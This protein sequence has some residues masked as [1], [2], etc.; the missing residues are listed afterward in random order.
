MPSSRV[1]VSLTSLQQQIVSVF[2]LLASDAGKTVASEERLVDIVIRSADLTPPAKSEVVEAIRDLE[3]KHVLVR[4][5]ESADRKFTSAVTLPADIAACQRGGAATYGP[6]S[7]DALPDAVTGRSAKDSTDAAW[8]RTGFLRRYVDYLVAIGI[9]APAAAILDELAIPPADIGFALRFYDSAFW[10][11]SRT[12]LAAVRAKPDAASADMLETL[13][14]F[15]LEAS[16]FEGGPV[17]QGLERAVIAAPRHAALRCATAAVRIAPLCVWTGRRDLLDRY[18]PLEG[19]AS[20]NAVDLAHLFFGKGPSRIVPKPL[21]FMAGDLQTAL[22]ALL[23]A[24]FA[25]APVR[26]ADA[27]R[28]KLKDAGN[29]P[30][31]AAYAEFLRGALTPTP[32]ADDSWDHWRERKPE[33]P[34]PPVPPRAA[35]AWLGRTL[36][37]AL[38][39]DPALRTSFPEAPHAL[40][41]AEAA[42]TAGLHFLAAQLGALLAQWPETSERGLALAAKAPPNMPLLWK[43]AGIARPWDPLLEELEKAVA[44]LAKSRKPRAAKKTEGT[45]LV[46]TLSLKPLDSQ[47]SLPNLGG[48]AFTVTSLALSLVKRRRDGTLSPVEKPS[49]FRAIR[50]A[51]LERSVDLPN[52]AIESIEPLFRREVPGFASDAHAADIHST[53]EDM[54]DILLGLRGTAGLRVLARN[55]DVRNQPPHASEVIEEPDV[56][57]ANI[58]LRTAWDPDGSLRIAAPP[59]AWTAKYDQVFVRTEPGRFTWHRMIPAV[60]P[61][62]DLIQSRGDRDALVIPKGGAEKARELLLGAAAAGLPVEGAITP[63]GDAADLKTVAGAAHI[64]ARLQLRDGSL[65]AQLRAR[66]VAKVPDLL[67]EPGRG[68]PELAVPSASEPFLLRR[69]LAG[70]RAV[71]DDVRAA[72]ADFAG[73]SEGDCDWRADEPARQLALLETLRAAADADPKRVALEWRGVA[74]N[75][76]DIRAVDAAELAGAKGADWWLGVEGSFRL[77]D[78]SDAS[79]RAVIEALPRRVGGYVPLD[80]RTWLR[81]TAGLRKRLEA[82]ATAGRVEGDTLRVS[83]AALPMLEEAFTEAPDGSEAGA[84]TLRLPAELERLAADFREAMAAEH[85]VP[86]GLSA[87]L[88]PYQREGFEWLARLA[89]CNLGA[90]LADDMGLGKTVQ[91]ISLLLERAAGGPSLVVAPA[92]V[93]GNWCAELARFAPGLHAVRAGDAAALPDDLGPGDIVVTSYGL[94]VS[95]EAQY[96]D[97]EWNVAVLDE[98]QAVKNAD[99]KRAQAVKR[100]RASCRFVATGTPVENRLSDLWSLFDFLNPGLLGTLDSFRRDLLDPSGRPL[101]ALKSLVRPLILRRL[102]GEVLRDLPEK[103]EITLD[104][105]LGEAERTAYE[106]LREE[107]VA[108]LQSG[109]QGRTDGQRRIQ[110]LAALTRLRRFCCAPGLV[111][112]GFGTGAKLEALEELLG[113][114]QA[115]GHRALVFSQFVDVLALVRPILE[116]RGWGYEYLDGA[117]PQAERTRRVE[118]FQK[119]DAPFFLISLKAGGTGLNLT[120]ANYV[121][122]LDPWW[123]PAVEDQAADRAHRI[124]QRNP[125]TV[126]RLVTRGTIEE[127]V[128]ALHGDKREL[129]SAV[130]EG[131]GDAKVSSADLLALFRRE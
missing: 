48:D 96:T 8:R 125:V 127:K 30:A 58:T 78:G 9:L 82:L 70:E 91:L 128:V 131:T 34:K 21:D 57:V 46:A 123:N 3:R 73:E 102:K 32:E 64:V 119:G 14:P 59:L 84:F 39:S 108:E 114:L 11:I 95:R 22:I 63:A 67:F 85:P 104:V 106:T 112:P 7:A 51:F 20:A 69:D 41:A 98:A 126:Y 101:P 19:L 111:L 75:R 24:R 18:T 92:S 110:I 10:Y 81:L 56:D 60:R 13:L 76:L 129:S 103:T 2:P 107:A 37:H 116:R 121:V 25:P 74:A 35:I 16:F 36:G 54:L 4:R 113:D 44:P 45:V 62:L 97:R 61:L 31:E 83:P 71:A 42:E 66:P 6:I 105:E 89:A 40:A 120:A 86:E 43:P 28:E 26:L 38:S 17:E 93:C 94:L 79:L 118:A 130:L 68:R 23:A 1:T 99:A 27:L 15:S 65:S 77:D 124:G 72:L 53:R 12:L 29:A 52:E 80:G 55:A 100:L 122:L 87:R 88:R 90:C 33:A 49:T 115:N 5:A 109:G 50:K 117:T 47:D